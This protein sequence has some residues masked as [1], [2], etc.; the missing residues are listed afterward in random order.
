[1]TLPARGGRSMARREVRQGTIS[2]VRLSSTRRDVDRN[3]SGGGGGRG[4]VFVLV[5]SLLV[6]FGV[7]VLA[8]PAVGAVA[9][10]LAEAN[11]AAMRL[12]FVAGLVEEDLRDRLT[13]PASADTASVRFKVPEGASANEVADALVAQGL[14]KDRL[15]L[16]YLI[17]TDDLGDK[18][19]AGSYVLTKNMSPRQVAERLAETPEQTVQVALREGLRLEQITAYLTTLGL[20][21]DTNEFYELARNPSA[22]LRKDFP[23][24]ATLPRGRSL[25]GY[26]GSGT[27][28]VYTD[29]KP[30]TLLSMLLEQWGKQ[31]GEGPLAAADRQGR[32]FYSVLA[33]ASIVEK[34]A[35]LPEERKTIAGVYVRRLER[36]MLL[37]S[38]PTVFYGYDTTQ[39]QK[40]GF[41]SWPNYAFWKP[42]GRS[43]KDID[44]PGDLER[45]QTYRRAGL[46]PGPICTPTRGA[47]EAAL[48]PDTSKGYLYFVA[49][50]NG[51]G[52]HK[53][54]RTFAEHQANLRR[55]G[56]T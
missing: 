35:T 15:A 47:I 20:E 1:M 33:L 37:Q 49:I 17:I 14:V 24:L 9:R 16:E 52:A 29:V 13:T 39:L 42:P 2:R 5:L 18:I 30:D 3:G 50:P 4:I 23:F 56:Y 12:P 43:L 38:D 46:I 8:R 6:L 40:L 55:Y 26:L 54:A 51:G 28:E 25:E 19:Q 36:G 41:S 22:T 7:F 10:G 34:E 48:D 27:F 31:V 53:F 44:L 11:P 21:M 32:D 45:Y